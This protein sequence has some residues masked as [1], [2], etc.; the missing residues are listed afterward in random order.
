MKALLRTI[1]I[2]FAFLFVFNTSIYAQPSN[3]LYQISTIN[4]LLQGVYD[5]ELTIKD[6]KHVFVNAKVDH[7]C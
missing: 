4:A 2:A 7:L 3:E 6:L 1:T 5:G